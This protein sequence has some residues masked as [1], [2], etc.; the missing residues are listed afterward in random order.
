MADL[1]VV[2]MSECIHRKK[3]KRQRP[4][5]NRDTQSEQDLCSEQVPVLRST[6]LSHAGRYLMSFL[7]VYKVYPNYLQ[8]RKKSTSI[9]GKWQVL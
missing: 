9:D 2:K 7:I 1:Y 8:Y 4:D 5:L 3:C 6:R